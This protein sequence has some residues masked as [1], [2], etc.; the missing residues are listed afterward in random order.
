MQTQA[1]QTELIANAVEAI[2]PL[3]SLPGQIE[4]KFTSLI[5]GLTSAIAKLNG[6]CNDNVELN[7]PSI[8]APTSAQQGLSDLN[9]DSDYNDLIPTEFYTELNV[10]DDDLSQRAESIQLLVEQQRDLFNSIL[11][12]PAQVYKQ[13]GE[14]P[15]ELGK[16]GDYYVNTTN[17]VSYGPKISSTD[18]GNPLN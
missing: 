13:E 2:K 16:T 17:N 12:A 5:P 7:I 4:S 18:W 8:S 9:T 1:L 3:Q 6:A 10:S 14:P 15:A 11:E